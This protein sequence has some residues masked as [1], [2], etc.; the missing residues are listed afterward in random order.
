[1]S[2]Y[3]YVLTAL[4]LVIITVPLAAQGQV[5]V[6]GYYRDDGTYVEGHQRTSPDGSPYNNYSFPG[7]YNPNTGEI[8]SGNVSS[9]LENYYDNS[10]SSGLGPVW[11]DG[12]VRDDGT[13]VEGHWRTA[14]DGDPTNNYSYPGNYNPNSGQVTGSSSIRNKSSV[15]ILQNALEILGHDPGTL[16]GIWGPNTKSAIRSFQRSQDLSVDGIPGPET[17]SEIEE[18]LGEISQERSDRTSSSEFRPGGRTSDNRHVEVPANAKLNY[19]GDGWVCKDGYHR[20]GNRC[21]KVAVPRNAKLNYYGD[22]WVCEDGYH[23]DGNRCAKVAVPRNAKLN[24]Y[25]D[26]WVCEDG[27]HRDGNRC[28]KV[29]VPRNAKLNYYGDGWVCEDGYHRDG[30]RCIKQ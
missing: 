26:G 29:A 30:N 25:G 9:Y 10:E 21:A 19:Y 7:N 27:Y 20:D 24:Y 5:W 2:T 12:Y 11:V 3:R 14:P 17:I 28:A 6:D 15:S 18:E 16:D 4:I 13:Y 23:R 22:G 8:T 1:M